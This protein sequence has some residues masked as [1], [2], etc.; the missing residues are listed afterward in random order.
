MASYPGAVKTWTSVIDNASEVVA[1]D[2]N[3][4][5]DEV[6]AIETELGTDPAS[7]ATDLKTRLAHVL[8]PDGYLSFDYATELTISAGSITPTQNLHTVDTQSGAA[9]DDLDTITAPGIGLSWLLLLHTEDNARNV[10]VKHNTGNI[11][12]P[13]G[14]DLTLDVTSDLFIAVY[15]MIIGKWIGMALSAAGL[16]TADNT[17]TGYNVFRGIATRVD[18]ITTNATLT[19]A[20][21]TVDCNTTGGD[22]TVTLPASTDAIKG[23]MYVIRKAV[24]ANTVTI[25]ASGYDDIN[26][27]SSITLS[28]QYDTVTLQCAGVNLS[29]NQW[30]IL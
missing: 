14:R 6:T 29:G 9:T 8:S 24:A 3:T 25:A 20:Y 13:A 23:L 21:H 15:D 12:L 17:W 18:T 11:L 28:S 2:I 5:Y 16:L 1:A 4:L 22:I 10:V 19:N 27:Q 30:Y 26:G 7:T